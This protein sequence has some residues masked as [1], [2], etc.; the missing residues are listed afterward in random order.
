MAY[1]GGVAKLASSLG[2][3]KSEAQRSYDNYWKMNEGLGKLKEAIEKYY[4]T[5]GLKK[6][7]PAWDGR[8]L[9][10]R[11]KNIL[12]NLAGQS[13]G[14]I[15]MSYAACFMDAWLGDLYLDD[16]GRPY[17]LYKGKVVRR[18]SM[19]H[20]EYSWEVEDGVEEEIRLMSVRA[21]VKAGE[22]LNLPLE[23]DGEGKMS[24]EGSWRDVH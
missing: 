22:L 7:I 14:A 10:A 20:D 4:D 23:L 12:I 11:G 8:I 21:I 3:S 9:S 17:Y 15:A 1:G 19:V 5:K 24:F 2:L 16:M 13:C 18:I 6:Y